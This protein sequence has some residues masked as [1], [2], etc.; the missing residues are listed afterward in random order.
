MT[1]WPLA[2]HFSTALLLSLFCCGAQAQF[3]PPGIT[4]TETEQ[5][6]DGL[7]TFRW[8]AYRSVFIV[9]DEG[10]IAT[11][12][13]N[14]EAAKKYREEIARVTDQPVKYLVYSHSHW[15]H[16]SGGQ[17]FKDEGAT[18][19]AQERCV[20][21]MRESPNPDV[22]LPDRTF[23]DETEIMFGERGIALFYYGPSHDTC[24]AAMVL[25]PWNIL[26]TVDLV[27]PPSG[28]YMPWDPQVADFHFYNAVN[29]LRQLEALIERER[30]TT[31]LGAHLVPVPLGKGQFGGMAST[32]PASAVAERRRFWEQ[33]M[34]AVKAEMDK[35]TVS[36]MVANRIDLSPFE[37]T[38]N[39][40]KKDMK[41]LV[42]RIAAYYSIGR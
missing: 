30:I 18:I 42:N 29:Y 27:T 9:T 35:G 22:I 40:N 38:R 12:P 17:I 14:P 24:L 7:Y 26:V 28:W 36:F 21:N 25:R 20:D 4:P 11:D 37:D 16:V 23:S 2:I 10:V 1:R 8:G 31:L 34:T 32:G 33:L 5:L 13:I 15:D 19:V 39:F 6:A 3:V 41:L